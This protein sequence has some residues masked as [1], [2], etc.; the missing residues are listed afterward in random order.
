MNK[1]SKKNI[2]TIGLTCVA[3]TVSAKDSTLWILNKNFKAILKDKLF[4]FIWLFMSMAS[5]HALAAPTPN[6][7]EIVY[8]KD[9]RAPS[10]IFREGFVPR[11]HNVNLLSHLRGISVWAQS[12]LQASGFI[13]T[14]ASRDVARTFVPD[15]PGYIYEIV[16]PSSTYDAQL[17][18]E[19]AV[20][21]LPGGSEERASWTQ[22]LAFTSGL[23]QQQWVV[24]DRIRPGRIRGAYQVIPNPEDPSS[25]IVGEFISNPNFD[26]YAQPAASS[27]YYPVRTELPSY[28]AYIRGEMRNSLRSL[29]FSCLG[30]GQSNLNRNDSN[31]CQSPDI[32]IEYVDEY[33]PAL[34]LE[35][36]SIFSSNNFE[37]GDSNQVWSDFTGDGL[38]DHCAIKSGIIVCMIQDE[39]NQFNAI[40]QDMDDTGWSDSRYWVD[41]NGDG[42]TDYCRV[43][44][45]TKLRCSEGTESG[46]FKTAIT[47]GYLDAGWIETRRWA[48]LDSGSK[49]KSFCRQV[50]QYGSEMAIRCMTPSNNFEDSYMRDIASGNG[51]SDYGY[52]ETQVWSDVNGDNKDDFCFVT[53][54]HSYQLH[55]LIVEDTMMGKDFNRSIRLTADLEYWPQSL[56]MVDIN[57]DQ[58]ADYC[59]TRDG[60]ISC[61]INRDLTLQ[62]GSPFIGKQLDAHLGTWGDINN[63]GVVDLCHRSAH[64]HISC[65]I[66]SGSSGQQYSIS[67]HFFE[68][69]HNSSGNFYY[70]IIGTNVYCSKNADFNE[71]FALNIPRV[72]SH[73]EILDYES[74]Y[75]KWVW[76]REPRYNEP[77]TCR[78]ND[79]CSEPG[80]ICRR[81]HYF[82]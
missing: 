12:G 28:F 57:N 6:P 61:R 26:P 27:A 37:F 47:S 36:A 62:Q 60:K 22:T 18:L 33:S 23:N 39:N 29:A 44:D 49:K 31:E 10:T 70:P 69:Y 1:I 5:F 19:H 66:N 73:C 35:L 59:F 43:V 45:R 38:I 79:F 14:T 4:A 67:K 80:G 48:S 82:N 17:S 16:P 71:C 8:R 56:A 65:F 24:T 7:P 51:R 11:G 81:W 3:N 76:E 13:S 75:G 72:D 42:I 41:F 55:C 74:S 30:V 52:S 34:D 53:G 40:Y 21:Q 20:E 58:K 78:A 63:D 25:P 15:Q 46:Y 32:T 54:A 77:K 50:R 64:G 2:I 9:S 68:I